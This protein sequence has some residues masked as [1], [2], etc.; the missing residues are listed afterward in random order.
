[1]RDLF[2][3]LVVFGTIPL[4]FMRP[5]VGVLVYSWLSYMNPHRLGWGFATTFPF[6]QVSVIVTML[7][8]FFSKQRQSIPITPITV[9]LFLFLVWITISSSVGLVPEARW[10]EWGRIMKIQVMIFV[11]MMLMID[12]EKI[13]HL[14]WVIAFSIGFFGIKGGV[15]T[16]ATAGSYRVWGPEGTFIGGNNEMA[17]A[18]IMIIPLFWY[19]YLEHENK[20]LRRALLLCVVLCVFSVLGSYSR[21]AFLA[22]AGMS[23]FLVLKST[24]KVPIILAACVIIPVVA[25]FM[26][27]EWYERM[28]TIKTYEQDDSAMGRINSWR[29]ATNLALDRPLTGGS[30]GVFNRELFYQYV[31]DV[32]YIVDAHS[33]Y[34]EVLAE[35]GFVGLFLFLLLFAVGFF[36]AGGIIRKTKKNSELKW[37]NNL[38]RMV[39]ISLIG[40]GLNGATLGLAY[41]DLPYHILSIIVVTQIVVNKELIKEKNN[42]QKITRGRIKAMVPNAR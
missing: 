27:S 26:P 40:Y 36:T 28:S 31:P 39:Q 4:V 13:N 25:S 23:F 32:T 2:V 5:Y 35:Q 17:L 34:F 11:T 22:L 7:S 14:V 18:L 16:I 3:V 24:K 37:A 38:M 10:D 9:I 8:L 21:G 41:F 6:A 20:W 29:F 30:F 1:M 42:S 19:L 33:I 12:K 15:F